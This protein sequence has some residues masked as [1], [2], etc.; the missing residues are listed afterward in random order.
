MHLVADVEQL[1]RWGLKTSNI[2]GQCSI[3][4]M[5]LI[6]SVNLPQKK[7][8]TWPILNIYIWVN[9]ERVW[10]VKQCE[11]VEKIIRVRLIEDR[12]FDLWESTKMIA[13]K[14]K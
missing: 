4:V 1:F 7:V 5:D 6:Y 12:L 10:E 3:H 11:L 13:W 2:T 9:F 14:N 8:W